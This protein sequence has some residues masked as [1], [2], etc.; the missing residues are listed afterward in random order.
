MLLFMESENLFLG[1][2]PETLG[3]LLFG[4]VMVFI[5]V[6]LR[7][8][9][10]NDDESLAEREPVSM[11]AKDMNQGTDIANGNLRVNEK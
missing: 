10:G 7:R 3:M 2:V 11:L 1:V 4:I 9:L 5:A 6:G 8:F